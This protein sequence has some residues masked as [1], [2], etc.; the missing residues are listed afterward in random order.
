[1]LSSSHLAARD[2]RLQ[3]VLDTEV[4]LFPLAER[5]CWKEVLNRE[6]Y[7]SKLLPYMLFAEHSF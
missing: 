4:T 2:G 5:E 7:V 3:N 6:N 1:M